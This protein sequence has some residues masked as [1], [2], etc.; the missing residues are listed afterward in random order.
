M[1]EEKSLEYL[2]GREIFQ[3]FCGVR[4]LLCPDDYDKVK[5]AY[6]AFA[7]ERILPIIEANVGV[8]HDN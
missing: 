2:I 8:N 5:Q 1:S 6:V 4:Y 7:R 3:Q